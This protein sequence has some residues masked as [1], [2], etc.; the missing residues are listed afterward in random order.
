MRRRGD[1]WMLLEH[2]T[3]SSRTEERRA[4]LLLA[5]K[6]QSRRPPSGPCPRLT[7]D[8]SR[9][10]VQLQRE[11]LARVQPLQVKQDAEKNQSRASL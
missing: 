9:S 2:P 11:N 3:L 1:L 10:D 8:P 6:R 7:P 4:E 5:T